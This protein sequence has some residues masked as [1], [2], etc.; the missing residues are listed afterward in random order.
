MTKRTRSLE[1]WHIP[2]RSSIHQTIGAVN[3]LSEERFNGKSWTGGRKETFNTELKKWGLTEEGKPLS[4]SG[5]RT[6]E[7][8]FK[9]LGFI[10]IDKSTTPPTLIVTDVGF[11]LVKKHSL[12]QKFKTLKEVQ[13]NGQLIKTSPVVK[14]Q[15]VKLQITNPIIREDCVNILVF[16]FRITV[17]LLLELGY[18]DIEEIAS[19][20]FQMKTEDQYDYIKQRIQNFRSLTKNKRKAEIEQFKK[21]EEGMLTLVKAPSARY[22]MSLCE[23]TALC[24][25]KRGKISTLHLLDGVEDEVRKILKTFEDV[26]PFDFQDNAELWIEYYGKPNRL[27]PPKL[28]NITFTNPLQDEKI[29]VILKEGRMVDGETF[30]EDVTQMATPLFE[31]EEYSLDIYDSNTG[32]KIKEEQFSI[33]EKQNKLEIDISKPTKQTTL[34]NSEIMKMID[35]LLQSRDRLDNLYMNRLKILSSLIGLNIKASI[36]IL[37]GGRLEYL[38]YRFL[39]NLESEGKI[40]SVTWNGWNKKYGIHQPAPGG[41][42]GKSDLIFQIYDTVI[43]L[44]VTTIGDTRMQWSAEGASVPDHIVKFKQK[45][46]SSLKIVGIFSAPKLHDQLV[47]NLGQHSK[48]DMVPILCYPL[49]QLLQLLVES[50]KEQIK[51]RI[52]EDSSKALK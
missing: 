31:N 43:L 49:K 47:K 33:S 17:R 46:P 19:I 8:L 51:K 14:H 24:K 21:T 34:T 16:P 4:P 52:E 48:T 6:L 26:K 20:L 10:Y 30:D 15:M 3:I 22:F 28:V 36:S 2:K 32:T 42:A 1:I 41:R 38:V 9:Y 13:K 5:R 29:V 44:E 35:D 45:S 37:R 27:K 25:V 7:A 40:D 23:G 50:S 18:L 39:H 11:D 12:T